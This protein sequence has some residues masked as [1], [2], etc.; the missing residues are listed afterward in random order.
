MAARS[1]PGRSASPAPGEGEA[2]QQQKVRERQR[3]TEAEGPLLGGG[4]HAR[5]ASGRLTSRF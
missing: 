2:G 3:D 4:A 1:A 5:S